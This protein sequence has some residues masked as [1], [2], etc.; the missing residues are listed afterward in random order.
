MT[1]RATHSGII[2]GVDGSSPSDAAVRWGVQ[3]AMLRQASLALV[4]VQSAP[5]ADLTTQPGYAPI[6]QEFFDAQ[7][8][9]AGHVI[10]HSLRVIEAIDGGHPR[11]QTE[12][13]TSAPVPALIE[14]SEQAD[15]VVVGSRGQ[16]GLRRAL[17]GS[18]S[19]GLVNH[20][21]C[22]VAVI[23]DDIPPVSTS[24]V[25][26]GV[27]GSPS[28]ERALAVAFDEARWRKS[29]L[30]ALHAWHDADMRG[31]STAD[32]PSREN[33]ASEALGERLVDW[34]ERYPD[35]AVSRVVMWDSPARHLIERS[36]MAQLVVVGSRGR[37]GFA[38][39]LLGSVS[40]AVA[41][42]SRAPVIV[43]R[44]R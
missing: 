42:S 24:P 36:K 37:G 21:R 4:H 44:A 26:V 6:A 22:P 10:R 33:A 28:S 2:V 19:G 9:E 32:W 14:L 39:M 25:L 34:S 5:V 12:I 17:L 18:V 3:E 23:H 31:L 27:D 38:G 1:S 13:V 11:V 41:E 8:R 15:M 29:D 35:V 30:V 7:R 43:A 16:G 40:T 20:A